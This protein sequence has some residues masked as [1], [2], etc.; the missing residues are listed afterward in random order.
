[1]IMDFYG[2]LAKGGQTDERWWVV[3]Y[4]KV[5]LVA[6][7]RVGKGAVPDRRRRRRRDRGCFKL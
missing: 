1:M 2:E 4:D 5:C 6:L 7:Q 3:R